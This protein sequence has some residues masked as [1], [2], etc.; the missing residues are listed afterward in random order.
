[1]GSLSRTRE[2]GK[3]SY[4]LT[5]NPEKGLNGH[6][7][8]TIDA[9]GDIGVVPPTD[10]LI[11]V[12]D[13][14]EGH[15]KLDFAG[16]ETT[17]DRDQIDFVTRVSG[18]NPH[19]CVPPVPSQKIAIALLSNCDSESVSKNTRKIQRFY[20]TGH[21]LSNYGGF[22]EDCQ[23]MLEFPDYLAV[24]NRLSL[25]DSRFQSNIVSTHDEWFVNMMLEYTA[26]YSIQNREELEQMLSEYN[27]YEGLLS[28]K[29]TEILDLYI[30]KYEER[31]NPTTEP[32][33]FGLA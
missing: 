1:M 33:D 6:A 16:P 3:Y 31:D 9:S 32:S 17:E 13:S 18:R 24:M 8:L 23:Y 7:E 22:L 4:S 29:K 27:G 5:L 25:D 2:V 21:P 20:D 10:W 15:L 30:L 14:Q 26:K 19:I 12:T 28:L 11:T